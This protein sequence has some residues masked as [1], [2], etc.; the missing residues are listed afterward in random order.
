MTDELSKLREFQTTYIH[1]YLQKTWVFRKQEKVLWSKA[2]TVMSGIRLLGHFQ[3]FVVRDNKL[4]QESSMNI[5]I[6]L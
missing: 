2:W 5:L 6:V 3:C 4:C 1:F